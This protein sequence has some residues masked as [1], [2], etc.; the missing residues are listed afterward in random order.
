MLSSNIPGYVNYGIDA[1]I[2]FGGS[3]LENKDR[4]Q[5]AIDGII[6][7]TDLGL[8]I[9]V[10]PGGGPTDNTIEAL[11]KITPFAENTHHQACARAQ[12]QTGLMISDKVFSNKLTPCNTLENVRNAL[13]DH[14]VA[15]LLPSYL[16]FA[17]D[18]FEKT[19]D[20]SSD[21][22]AAWFAWLVK[23]Q[24][25]VILTNVDG[26]YRDGKVSDEGY[27]I[28][29]ITASELIQMGHT[30]VDISTPYF[31]KQEK[32]N[33]LVING[34]KAD[35]LHAALTGKSIKGTKIYGR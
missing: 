33:A 25:L 22:M 9:L 17:V 8:R 26:V 35:M 27:F 10:I 30:A 24:N 21:G 18:P 13:D 3:L 1:V 4:C 15:V 23:A 19:W 31:L 12:D 14:K 16:I 11:D 5:F 34:N 7:C 2:K 6:K 29:E 32:L 28:P 20:I